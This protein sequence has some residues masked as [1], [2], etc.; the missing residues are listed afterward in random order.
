[1]GI[2]AKCGGERGPYGRSRFAHGTIL[3][4]GGHPTA[5]PTPRAPSHISPETCGGWLGFIILDRPTLA[6][7][8]LAE[9]ATLDA[10]RG[11]AGRGAKV[12]QPTT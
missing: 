10:H 4:A 6:I 3:A 11:F 9:L 2:T 1:M 7:S 12:F 8:S 5:A